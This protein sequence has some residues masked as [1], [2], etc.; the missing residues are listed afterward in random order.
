MVNKRKETA[1]KI[2]LASFVFFTLTSLIFYSIIQTV[3]Y[4]GFELKTTP[5]HVT[6]NFPYSTIGNYKQRE[7]LDNLPPSPKGQF[8]LEFQVS[9]SLESA[10]KKVS[11]LKEKGIKSFYRPL[12]RDG[13][14][15]Y[16]VRKGLFENKEKA[17]KAARRIKMINEEKVRVVSL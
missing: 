9:N 15:Y 17:E 13:L 2:F 12:S 8:T 4:D 14:I 7:V 5:N 1:G 6:S 10:E 3:S 11:A 16:Q